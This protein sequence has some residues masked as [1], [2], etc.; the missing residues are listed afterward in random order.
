MT[1]YFAVSF[2]QIFRKRPLASQAVRAPDID[3]KKE[4]PGIGI[5]SKAYNKNRGHF[6]PDG[7]ISAKP[8][9]LTRFSYPSAWISYPFFN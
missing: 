2:L 4:I 7:K 9:F 6:E 8:F 5:I 3:M 1:D